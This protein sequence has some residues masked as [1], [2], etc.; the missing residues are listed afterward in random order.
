M[1]TR[2]SSIIFL[3]GSNN[4]SLEQYKI[5]LGLF[6]YLKLSYNNLGQAKNN[7][8]IWLYILYL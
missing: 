7:T 8:P 2:I 6:L 5:V 4:L 1:G 3:R